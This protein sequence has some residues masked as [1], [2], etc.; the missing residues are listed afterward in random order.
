MYF[1]SEENIPMSSQ[2][3]LWKKKSNAIFPSDESQNKTE[4]WVQT[5]LP[6]SSQDTEETLSGN[7]DP[8]SQTT[9]ISS[10]PL[11]GSITDYMDELHIHPSCAAESTDVGEETGPGE[12][13]QGQ[14][15]LNKFSFSQLPF[16]RYL[17]EK[18]GKKIPAQK[19]HPNTPR[20]LS[21]DNQLDGCLSKDEQLYIPYRLAK[22]YIIKIAKDMH[23]MKTGYLKSIKELEQV[24]KES[25]EQ[26]IMVVKNQYYNKMKNLKAQLEAYQE[27]VDKKNQYWQDRTKRLEEENSKL[28]QEKEEFLNQITLQKENW[29]KEKA[30]LLETTTQKLNCLYM[31]HTLTVK[32][33]RKTRQNLEKAQKIVDF[34]MDLPC[35]QRRALITSDEVTENQTTEKTANKKMPV[36]TAYELETTELSESSASF[37]V[38]MEEVPG[39]LPQKKLLLEVKTILELIRESLQKQE[40]EIC[41]LL[42]SEQCNNY[43]N[44]NA[45][46]TT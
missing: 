44:M 36:V 33:F 27:V 8:I 28:R 26:A 23:Q 14:S 16:V 17:T 1:T 12:I 2:P 25:Q 9:I 20:V 11:P 42:Q 43:P 13:G 5:V 34:Q 30:W 18:K 15:L 10:I 6:S 35:D 45:L 21:H 39:C 24:G 46:L 37:V 22:L 19:G 41:E 40:T 4:A 32:E 3:W 7:A 29:D 38:E 31:Q